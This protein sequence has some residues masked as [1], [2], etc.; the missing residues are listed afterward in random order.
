MCKGYASTLLSVI[1]NIDKIKTS[2]YESAAKRCMWCKAYTC[3]VCKYLGDAA[4][5]DEEV[6]V[7]NIE[8]HRV[9]QVL[10]L[11]GLRCCSIDQVLVLAAN[12]HLPRNSDLVKAFVANWAAERKRMHKASVSV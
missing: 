5:H 7:V 9:E 11:T 1:D 10:H 12:H 8:L 3:V 6:R 4:L 2:T